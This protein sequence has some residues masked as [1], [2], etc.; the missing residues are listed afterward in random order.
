MTHEQ[1]EA[2]LEKSKSKEPVFEIRFKTRSPIKGLFI[3]T[4][5]Y[6]E[7]SRKNLWRIV[8]EKY[9]DEYKK[10]LSGNLA[11]IFNG[12]EFTRLESQS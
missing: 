2:V 10:T 8:N 1:I 12:T 11:R 4:A 7:L 9:I 3:K 5:D 6:S